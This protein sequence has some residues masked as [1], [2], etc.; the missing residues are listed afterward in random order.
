MIFAK[1]ECVLAYKQA[2]NVALWLLILHMHAH[3]HWQRHTHTHRCTEMYY[4]S[5]LLPFVL[6]WEGSIDQSGISLIRPALSGKDWGEGGRNHWEWDIKRRQKKWRRRESD[7]A[8]WLVA[9]KWIGTWQHWWVN[10]KKR[11][12]AEE[13]SNMEDTHRQKRDGDVDGNFWHKS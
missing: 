1:N 9:L 7:E 11:E 10:N 3:T 8:L 13:E 4:H 12:C 2:L 5:K 6:P